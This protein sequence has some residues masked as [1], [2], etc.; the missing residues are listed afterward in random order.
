MIQSYYYYTIWIKFGPTLSYMEKVIYLLHE[1]SFKMSKL[2]R[3]IFPLE[4]ITSFGCRFWTNFSF[5]MQSGNNQ[6]NRVDFC[7]TKDEIKFWGQYYNSTLTVRKRVKDCFQWTSHLFVHCVR[8]SL[9]CPRDII[10][11]GN[12]SVLCIRECTAVVLVILFSFLLE[13]L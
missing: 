13:L 11:T 9:K 2:F 1:K 8:L 10:T 6:I 3:F 7:I 12:L 5:R 4:F